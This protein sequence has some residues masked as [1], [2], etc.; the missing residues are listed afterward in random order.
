MSSFLILSKVWKQ[1]N[2]GEYFEKALGRHSG[3]SLSLFLF[4]LPVW[5]QINLVEYFMKTLGQHQ[6]ES[7]SIFLSFVACVETNKF[8]I[9]F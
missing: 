7:L 5:K 2:L 8:G 4:L 1:I 3:E 9:V 6:D